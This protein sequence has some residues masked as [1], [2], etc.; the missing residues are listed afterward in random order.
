[1]I[2]HKTATIGFIGNNK[3]YDVSARRIGELPKPAMRIGFLRG[4][5]CDFQIKENVIVGVKVLK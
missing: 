1:M 5:Q 2:Q 3:V 4:R